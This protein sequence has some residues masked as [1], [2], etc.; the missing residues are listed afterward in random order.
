MF[1]LI[2][3]TILA[4]GFFI[5]MGGVVFFLGVKFGRISA[6]TR[7]RLEEEG[8]RF[9]FPARE[10]SLEQEELRKL[11]IEA[12]NIENFGTGRPQREVVC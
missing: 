10:E 7:E 4:A 9:P 1:E 8:E 11:A 2:S 6:Q 5:F 12:E 3:L